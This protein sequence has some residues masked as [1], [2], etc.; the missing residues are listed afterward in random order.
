MQGKHELENPDLTEAERM[1]IQGIVDALKPATGDGSDAIDLMQLMAREQQRLEGG[2]DRETLEQQ[3]RAARS[4]APS[5]ADKRPMPKDK[6]NRQGATEMLLERL[7]RPEMQR[8]LA[9]SNS[10]GRF[11]Q[12]RLPSIAPNRSNTPLIPR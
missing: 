2:Q 12:P 6:K 7:R 5:A 9:Q 1:E 11:A 3:Q 10:A 8:L 4:V